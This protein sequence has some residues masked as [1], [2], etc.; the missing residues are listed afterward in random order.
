[1]RRERRT[2]SNEIFSLAPVALSRRLVFP[3]KRSQK[4]RFLDWIIG[5][6]WH[7]LPRGLSSTSAGDGIRRRSELIVEPRYAGGKLKLGD[8]TILGE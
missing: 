7:A 3:A 8:H 5:E 2:T 1:M 6:Y 4:P